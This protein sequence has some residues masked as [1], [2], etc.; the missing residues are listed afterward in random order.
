MPRTP[1]EENAPRRFQARQ[2]MC[3]A[4]ASRR[5]PRAWASAPDEDRP[6]KEEQERLPKPSGDLH[7]AKRVGEVSPG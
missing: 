3:A 4:R 1:S 2:T 7:K 6:A 5:R